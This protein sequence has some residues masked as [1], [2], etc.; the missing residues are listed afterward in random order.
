MAVVS[1]KNTENDHHFGCCRHIYWS[2]WPIL[3]ICLISTIDNYNHY[4]I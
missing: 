2:N 3:P 1:S 4:K